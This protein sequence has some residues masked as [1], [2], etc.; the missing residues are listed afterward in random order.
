MKKCNKFSFLWLSVN[1]FNA[2]SCAIAAFIHTQNSVD[3]VRSEK[4]SIRNKNA[5]A[6]YCSAIV[7]YLFISNIFLLKN[8]FHIDLMVI[9]EAKK[10]AILSAYWTKPFKIC[11]TKSI[12]YKWVIYWTH[13]EK[14]RY[15]ITTRRKSTLHHSLEKNTCAVQYN[16]EFPSNITKNIIY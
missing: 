8:A 15:S 2:I 16:F 10:W 14:S 9:E 13:Q 12:F 3:I 11:S 5:S 1:R 6:F 7:F 4:Q